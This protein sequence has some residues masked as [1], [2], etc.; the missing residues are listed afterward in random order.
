MHTALFSQIG[1]DI[2]CL[3][4]LVVYHQYSFSIIFSG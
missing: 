1:L 4:L 2:L 3:D